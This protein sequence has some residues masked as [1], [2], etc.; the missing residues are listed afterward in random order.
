M[1]I[2]PNLSAQWASYGTTYNQYPARLR[3]PPSP[4][5]GDC[6]VNS[7]TL[8]AAVPL[9][10]GRHTFVATEGIGSLARLPSETLLLMLTLSDME[11]LLVMRRVNK[12]LRETVDSLVEWKKVSLSLDSWKEF[13]GIRERWIYRP[14]F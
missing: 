8:A 14:S 6:L 7:A 3:H 2:R 13:C 4:C 10:Y 5:F 12:K 9:D 1:P 11:S